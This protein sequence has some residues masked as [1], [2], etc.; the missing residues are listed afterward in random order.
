MRKGPTD[1]ISRPW[2]DQSAVLLTGWS[3]SLGFLV[4]LSRYGCTLGRDRALIHDDRV[5]L[6]EGSALRYEVETRLL[7][8]SV[9]ALAH[10]DSSGI[11]LLFGL[12]ACEVSFGVYR[13]PGTDVFH[14][15]FFLLLRATNNHQLAIRLVLQ[16]QGHFIEHGL[17]FIVDARVLLGVVELAVADQALADHFRSGRCNDTGGAACTAGESVY[18]RHVDIYAERSGR[19]I[20]GIKGSNAGELARLRARGRLA[21]FDRAGAGPEIPALDFGL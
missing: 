9:G 21:L 4:P 17:A 11:N 19:N 5:G 18:V 2:G 6:G 20:G 3:R 8:A 14:G 1:R 13:A 15:Y 7:S 10:F 12:A 16:T